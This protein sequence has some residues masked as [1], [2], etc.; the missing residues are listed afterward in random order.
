MPLL[1]LCQIEEQRLDLRIL[2]AL[3]RLLVEAVI[4]EL[5]HF[6][7]LAHLLDVQL[8]DGPGRLVLDETL[9]IGTADQ[10]DEITELLLVK[11]GQ[12]AAML[13]F[14]FRHLDEDLGGGR[15]GVHQRMSKAGIGAGVVILARYGEGDQLLFGEV[16]K[17]L[18]DRVL[19]DLH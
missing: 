12:P 13:V 7:A 17:A 5:D 2:R 19:S 16:G 18:H 10:R 9:D 11:L 3:G 4:L 15:I 1:G 14:F 6:G 8:A